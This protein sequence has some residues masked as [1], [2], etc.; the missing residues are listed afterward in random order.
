MVVLI[1]HPGGLVSLYAHLDDT[2]A[3]PTIRIGDTVTANQ[4]IGFVGLTGLTTGPH[5]HFAVVRGGQ[6]IDPLSV[7]TS[8]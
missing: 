4:V 2:F 7:L 3:R 1:A 6:P 8:R 5:L